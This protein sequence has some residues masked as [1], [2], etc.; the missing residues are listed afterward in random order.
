[1]RGITSPMYMRIMAPAVSVSVEETRK[2]NEKSSTY[3]RTYSTCSTVW[4][5]R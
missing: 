4:E 1:V 2:L 3:G 5:T